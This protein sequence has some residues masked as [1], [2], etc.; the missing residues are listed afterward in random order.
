M[1]QLIA[2]IVNFGS[3]GPSIWGTMAA[4]TW[5]LYT[6]LCL[7]AACNANT[8][9]SVSWP[10]P[11]ASCQA[12]AR[13]TAIQSCQL[14]ESSL[15]CHFSLTAATTLDDCL[16]G[17]E[18]AAVQAY[19]AQ[20][21]L[22]NIVIRAEHVLSP[23]LFTCLNSSSIRQ[24]SVVTI[25]QPA[26]LWSSLAA[27]FA[28]TELLVVTGTVPTQLPDTATT[29]CLFNV[30]FPAVTTP[31]SSDLEHLSTLYIDTADFRAIA[32]HLLR[33]PALRR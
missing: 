30:P 5:F 23:R 7:I 31:P 22:Q 19:L 8:D 29:L 11:T 4:T 10:A 13:R 9:C 33:M 21:C 12:L 24:L 18:S 28:S 16:P 26:S 32:P 15:T 27:A 6:I 3:R 2:T 1:Q 20:Q 14:S 25:T 17:S